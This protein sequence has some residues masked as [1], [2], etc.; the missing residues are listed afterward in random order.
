MDLR[1]PRTA[2]HC[3]IVIVIVFYTIGVLKQNCYGGVDLCT[4][5]TVVNS[6][7]VVCVMS[8]SNI[9]NLIKLTEV[10]DHNYV[11]L[12]Y[13]IISA[14]MFPYVKMVHSIWMSC[15]IDNTS[16]FTTG[17]HS[18]FEGTDYVGLMSN[19]VCLFLF[20]MEKALLHRFVPAYSA[21]SMQSVRTWWSL[22]YPL[23]VGL[24]LFQY[25][26]FDS[27]ANGI[28]NRELYEI[29]SL[30]FCYSLMLLLYLYVVGINR[31]PFLIDREIDLNAVITIEPSKVA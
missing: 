20:V 17:I 26:S 4:D 12:L 29:L 27:V 16:L 28:V 22:V 21:L 1:D 3:L 19:V 6:V 23:V 11:F 13:L 30:E 14:E 9:L 31:K 2:S 15:A 7:L 8:I 24:I 5:R 10:R 25:R 18:L